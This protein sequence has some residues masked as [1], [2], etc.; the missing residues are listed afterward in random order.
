MPT[1][2]SPRVSNAR[3]AAAP[4]KPATPVTRIFAMDVLASCG[5]KIAGDGAGVNGA[6]P[7]KL[8][9]NG[10]SDRLGRTGQGHLTRRRSAR[11]G[12]LGEG[13]SGDRRAK[14]VAHPGARD[15][16]S[17]G[18]ALFEVEPLIAKMILPWFGGSAAV[19][20]ACLLFFQ[21]ALL[22]GYL[23]AHL[24]TTRLPASWQWRVHIALLV[25][26]LACLPIVPGAPLETGRE[27]ES[28]AADPG[29]CCPRPSGCRFC[30]SPPPPRF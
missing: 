29:A 3:E 28:H 25:V 12:M 16:I 4:M 30:C 15:H 27:R 2:S 20:M 10:P 21:A 11:T 7:E 14:P 5:A 13:L 26:S 8:L 6:E 17:R 22:A 19:W 18:P 23:Y 24:L 9:V 1:T